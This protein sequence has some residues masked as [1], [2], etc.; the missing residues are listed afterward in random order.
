TIVTKMFYYS[1]LGKCAFGTEVSNFNWYTQDL[2]LASLIKDR[3]NRIVLGKF[4]FE[5]GIHLK[6][7]RA[8]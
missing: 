6:F 7:I 3:S 8:T 5:T 1:H 2:S 4:N